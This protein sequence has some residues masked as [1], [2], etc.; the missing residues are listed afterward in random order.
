M[1]KIEDFL[2]SFS[3]D[4]FPNLKSITLDG[5]TNNNMEKLQTMLPLI[6]NLYSFHS[7]DHTYDL[8]SVLLLPKLQTLSMHSLNLHLNDFHE[9]SSLKKLTISK[10]TL[11]ELCRLFSCTPMLTYLKVYIIYHQLDSYLVINNKKGSAVNLKKLIIND[12]QQGFEDLKIFIKQIPNLTSLNISFQKET[13]LDAY[14]WQNS[15]TTS[16]PLLNNFQ[17]KFICLNKDDIQNKFQQLQNSFWQDQHH[18][19]TEF[20]LDTDSAYIYTIPY[21]SNTFIL[22]PN[23]ERYSNSLTDNLLN[24]VT[25][26]IL[27]ERT[28]QNGCKFYS[29]NA[30]SL[31]LKDE[32]NSSEYTQDWYLTEE[33]I[34]S[35]EIIINL[36]HLK[37]LTIPSECKLD[38]LPVLLA[39]LQQS[40]Q[41]SS[42]TIVPFSERKGYRLVKNR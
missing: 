18:W 26:L 14:A 24:N 42:L 25:N 7:I 2:S 37:H 21:I 6:P 13:M 33:H 27:Y 16:L 5:V 32:S 17:F 20:V 10:C 8:S 40:P 34:P 41:L 31:T 11:N 39:L 12:F 9:I 28:I 23:T 30:E 35:L 15:I 1:V 4:E 36:N 22:T 29:P 3:L 19:N 38:S